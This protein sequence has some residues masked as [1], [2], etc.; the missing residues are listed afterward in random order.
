MF[1]GLPLP[2]QALVLAFLF[3]PSKYVVVKAE[4]V[5][6][7]FTVDDSDP[8]IRWS[9]GWNV[10]DGNNTLDYGGAHHFS[11]QNDAFA[12]FTFTGVAAYFL[13][14]LWPYSVQA[15]I[16]VDGQNPMSIDLRDYSQPFSQ[17]GGPET[18]TSAV[19]WSSGDLS[20]DTH[21]LNISFNN[22]G[23]SYVAVDAL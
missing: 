21:T 20:N 4:F 1:L 18:V 6:R 2:L 16:M 12:E 11:N 17:D 8:S 10:S 9:S 15:R 22:D 3:P 23:G 5:P 19:R 7:N 13:S 14:P